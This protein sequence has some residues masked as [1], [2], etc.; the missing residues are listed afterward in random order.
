MSIEPL[1]IPLRQDTTGA[2]RI[3]N[4][5]VLL[6]LVVRAFQDGATPETIVQR[7]ESL[8]LADVYAV[9]GYYLLHQDDVDAYLSAREH[10]AEKLRREIEA[11]QTPRPGF[12]QQLIER[13]A[14][15]GKNHAA[16][17]Q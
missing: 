7:Y 14:Q 3:G 17:G 11:V 4:T 5:R 8:K 13:L 15:R 1:N 2:Y 10:E 9:I 12:R 6:D 16:P